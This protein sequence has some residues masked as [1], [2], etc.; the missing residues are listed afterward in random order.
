MDQTNLFA[1]GVLVTLGGS[2]SVIVYLRRHLRR[3][4]V[5]LCGTE[6]RADF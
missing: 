3:L 2:V 1:A 5:E 6:E 4:L